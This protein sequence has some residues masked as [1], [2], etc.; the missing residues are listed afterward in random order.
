VSESQ[1]LFCPNCGAKLTLRAAMLTVVCEYCTSTML[2]SDSGAKLIGKVSAITD[3]GSPILLGSRGRYK[4]VDF[5]LSGRLQVSHAR[6]TWNEWQASFADGRIGWLAD[7]QGTFAMVLPLPSQSNPLPGFSEISPGAAINIGPVTLWAIDVRAATY[8]GAEGEL[9][10]YAYPGVRYL[11]ADF[12]GARGEFATLDYGNEATRA[13][14]VY[15]GERVTLA[16]L[17]LTP[18]RT[19]EGWKR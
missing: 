15:I 11:A 16:A 5:A 19:F 7:A 1:E 3:N 13:P 2:R 14:Q 9:S 17:Q 8:R 12:L 18:L 10:V 4:G 6:G